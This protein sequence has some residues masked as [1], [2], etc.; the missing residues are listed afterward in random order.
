MYVPGRSMTFRTPETETM[1]YG[2]K[3][4]TMLTHMRPHTDYTRVASGVEA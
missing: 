3:M 2:G 4:A 1:M